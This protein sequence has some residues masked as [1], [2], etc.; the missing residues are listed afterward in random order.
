MKHIA[1]GHIQNHGVLNL[2]GDG[3][4]NADAIGWITMNEI[5]GAIKGVNNPDVLG[6]LQAIGLI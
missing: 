2:A 3:Q 4:G 6:A 5:V 1:S